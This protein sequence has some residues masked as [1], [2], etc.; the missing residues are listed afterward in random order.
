MGGYVW[1]ESIET[2][3]MPTVMPPQSDCARF[4]R[5]KKTGKSWLWLPDLQAWLE[6]DVDYF[7]GTRLLFLSL[8][9]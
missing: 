2:S 3:N 4:A 1:A 6:V 8:N 9:N 7:L 5:D